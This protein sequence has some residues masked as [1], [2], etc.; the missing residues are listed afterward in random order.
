MKNSEVT[1]RRF[2]AASG[3]AV[4]AG[5]AVAR[6]AVAKKAGKLALLGGEPVHKGGWPGWPVWDP[7]R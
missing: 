7:E 2:L 1:R 6:G 5:G 3:A 4:L